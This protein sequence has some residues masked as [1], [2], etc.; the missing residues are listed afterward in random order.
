MIFQLEMGPG[1]EKAVADLG[2]MGRAIVEAVAAG[3]K[4]GGNR[5]KPSDRPGPQT[6][7]R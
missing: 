4:I 1:Y 3:L 2:A 7:K 5:R 6:Q